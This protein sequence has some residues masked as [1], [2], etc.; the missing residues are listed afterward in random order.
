MRPPAARAARR[1][2]VVSER[3]SSG[4]PAP[5]ALSDTLSTVPAMPVAASR[6]KP[7]RPVWR[8]RSTAL[9]LLARGPHEDLVE[10]DA[11]RTRDRESDDL[12]DVL[13]PDRGGLVELLDR[14]LRLVVGDVVH[15]LGG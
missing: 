8:D 5:Q 3:G 6:R 9:S 7:R 10:R 1:S 15:Q 12:G 14:L 11:V 4:D 13:G 2:G